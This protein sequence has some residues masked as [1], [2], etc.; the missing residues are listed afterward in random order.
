MKKTILLT[1]ALLITSFSFSGTKE[2]YEKAVANYSQTEN[3]E[4]FTNSLKKLAT[5]K[6]S[7]EYTR[8]SKIYL[9]EILIN[10]NKIDEAKKYLNEIIKDSKAN[11]NEKIAAYKGLF[12]TETKDENKLKHLESL[13][14]LD[15]ENKN[16]QASQISFYTYLKN[17]KK[18]TELYNKYTKNL[19][20]VDKENFDYILASQY[21]SNNNID[22]AEKIFN[23]LLKASDEKIREGANVKLGEISLS[24]GSIDNTIKYFEE[25]SKIAKQTNASVENALATL[26]YSKNDFAKS[27][28]K[29]IKTLELEKSLQSYYSVILLSEVTK[30]NALLEKTITEFKKELGENA[31]LTNALI[32]EFLLTVNTELSEKYAKLA[33]ETDK[34]ESANIILAIL[35]GSKGNKTE[36]L[37]YLQ[38]AKKANLTLPEGLEENI[39]K[40]K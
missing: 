22:E 14:S 19:K 40:L 36:A 11:K 3:I 26:Y 33:L 2:D 18:A 29:A 17:T 24:K 25:A 8:T 31:N 38:A 30:D 28:E 39:N 23:N 34:I 10:Q 9:A 5:N 13:L 32:A 20:A 21:L 37:K 16:L 6:T 1:L 15:S 35:E 7:D 27:K 12:Q 4:E